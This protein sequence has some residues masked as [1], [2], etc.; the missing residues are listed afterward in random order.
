MSKSVAVERPG[1]IAVSAVET[2]DPRRWVVLSVV[3]VGGFMA[4]LDASIMNVAVPAIRDDLHASFGEIEL[5]VAAYTLVYAILLITGGRLGDLFGRK[6]L[7]IA[8][9]A[10]FTV[11]SALCGLATS[12]LILIG[13]RALQG[14]G[15]ALAF[16][17]VLSLIQLTFTG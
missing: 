10:T 16:P 5:V 9:V 8:G 6:T 7:F 15:G 14:L 4:I 11:A 2:I 3:L 13:A 12:P 1:P 17:Q